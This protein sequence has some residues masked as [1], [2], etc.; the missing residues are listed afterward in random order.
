MLTDTHCHLNFHHFNNE[1][2]EILERARRGNI[3]RILNPGI[4]I[5]SS[6][7]AIKL[8]NKFGPV[9]AAIGVHPNNS[10]SWTDETADQLKEMAQNDKVVAIGEIGLDYFHD[11]APKGLQIQIFEEQLSIALFLN[12]PVVIHT[13]NKS[14]EDTSAIEDALDLLSKWV[15][16]IPP[17]NEILKA[18][19]GVLH[20]FSSMV[21]FAE[22]AAMYNFAVGITGPVTYKNNEPMR[23]VAQKINLQYILVETDAP[24]LTPHPYRGKRNEPA[25][26]DYVVQKIAEIRKISYD[27]VS[28]VTTFNSKRI[29]NW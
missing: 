2:V 28:S 3:H 12:K 21:Y 25:Y 6:K 18:N 26:V 29:F 8:A 13:R 22:F 19:P 17:D 27:Q 10:I 9:Y 16:N 11:A 4:D 23:T 1:R 5:S 24:F 20:S 7:E 14:K 15:V